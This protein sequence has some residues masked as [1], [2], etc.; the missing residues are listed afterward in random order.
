MMKENGWAIH[1]GPIC[2]WYW[3]KVELSR[4]NKKPCNENQALQNAE[5]ILSIWETD[6]RITCL[7]LP[8]TTRMIYRWKTEPM[9]I[10]DVQYGYVTNNL[11]N[12]GKILTSVSSKI[13]CILFWQP[14]SRTQAKNYV[15]K[16]E[17]NC[18][19]NNIITLF[20]DKMYST[21]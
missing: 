19:V 15:R 18:I 20:D 10:I 3:T 6:S 16:K 5:W 14:V 13:W 11:T 21:V 17:V 1:H 12:N 4:A 8:E 2:V 7:C 9:Q